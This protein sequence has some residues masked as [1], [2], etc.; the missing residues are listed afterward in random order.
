MRHPK[1]VVCLALAGRDAGSRSLGELALQ[2]CLGITCKSVFVVSGAIPESRLHSLTVITQSRVLALLA[3]LASMHEAQ[4]WNDRLR[5]IPAML[6][7][8][9]DVLPLLCYECICWINPT[10]CRQGLPFVTARFSSG[11]GKL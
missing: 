9:V 6:R 3:L 11:V 8:R 10:W 4:Y 5:L 7:L 2:C 1:A